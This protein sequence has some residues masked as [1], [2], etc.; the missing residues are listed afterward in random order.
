MV[1][2]FTFSHIPFS[3]GLG[4]DG[5]RPH[6]QPHREAD[7]E[8]CHG[9]GKAHRR[10]RNRAELG[11]EECV[12]EV[13]GYKGSIAHHHRDGEANQGFPDRAGGEVVVSSS[14]SIVHPTGRLVK[15][16]RRGLPAVALRLTGCN[17]L[18][19]I[20]GRG[21]SPPDR[22]RLKEFRRPPRRRQ[23]PARERRQ[24]RSMISSCISGTRSWK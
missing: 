17:S 18:Y 5:G 22:L 1:R 7:D 6:G 11:H 20:K 14:Y 21:L 2:R 19:L 13:K 16:G 8:G 10:Q 3:V 12:G 4:Y 15:K 9:E 23:V 24:V